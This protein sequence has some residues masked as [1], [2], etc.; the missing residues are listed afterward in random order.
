MGLS[1][2]PLAVG[3]VDTTTWRE[4][5]VHRFA[6]LLGVHVS[7][8]SCWCDVKYSAHEYVAAPKFV[9]A[10][11]HHIASIKIGEAR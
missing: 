7:T 4:R 5:A 2:D 8:R 3:A 6:K 11:W 1:M 9:Q 10:D